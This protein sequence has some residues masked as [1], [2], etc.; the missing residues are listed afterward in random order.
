MKRRAEA[1]RAAATRFRGAFGT[2]PG[3]AVIG[4]GELRLVELMRQIRQLMDHDLGPGR[5]HS[6]FKLVGVEH[7]GDKRFVLRFRSSALALSADRVV[8][9]IAVPGGAQERRQSAADDPRS[10]GEKISHDTILTSRL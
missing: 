4:G 10:A 1:A 6:A 3:I 5:S 7:V 2:N 8:P 9:A